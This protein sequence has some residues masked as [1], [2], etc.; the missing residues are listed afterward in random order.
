MTTLFNLVEPL[1]TT[2]VITNYWHFLRSIDEAKRIEFGAMELVLAGHGTVRGW[3]VGFKNQTIALC[4]A[5]VLH[6]DSSVIYVDITQVISVSFHE[7]HKILPFLTDG[8]IA[9]SPHEQ[10]PTAKELQTRLLKICEQIRTIWPAKLYFEEDPTTL[11]VD[12]LMN[13]NVV[14]EATLSALKALRENQNVWNEVQEFNALHVCNALEMRDVSVS[15]RES[16]ELELAFRF[17][18]ALPRNINDIVMTL[19]AGL[20]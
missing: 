16:T 7:S 18:R 10:K 20:F 6:K 19:M 11:T 4:T 12:E 5:P 1:S 2:D 8:A 3:P 14:M 13:L 17:S 9:R 15:K